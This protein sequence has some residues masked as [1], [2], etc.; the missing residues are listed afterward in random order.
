MTFVYTHNN[1]VKQQTTIT[2]AQTWWSLDE[3]KTFLK[4]SSDSINLAPIVAI[5]VYV[6]TNIN[7]VIVRLWI[8]YFSYNNKQT[9]EFNHRFQYNSHKYIHLS[10]SLNMHFFQ[11]KEHR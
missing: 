9:S 2:L 6:L 1:T 4:C 5:Q 10:L 8:C 11:N 3:S 7:I